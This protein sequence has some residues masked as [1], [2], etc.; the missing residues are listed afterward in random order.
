[1]R[2]KEASIWVWTHHAKDAEV[3]YKLAEIYILSNET[4]CE[5]ISYMAQQ[6]W[7]RGKRI[8]LQVTYNQYRS[9]I[10][11]STP[12]MHRCNMIE[13]PLHYNDHIPK[14]NSNQKMNKESAVTVV[15]YNAYDHHLVTL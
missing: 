14:Y 4:W 11:A 3:E 15:L 2:K 13:T 9:I 1:M 12:R 7:K 5:R 10:L 8:G 6:E